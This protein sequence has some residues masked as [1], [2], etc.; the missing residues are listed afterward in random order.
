M[1]WIQIAS[2]RPLHGR[3]RKVVQ[4]SLGTKSLKEAQELRW[5]WVNAYARAWEKAQA[6]PNMTREEI[7][8]EALAEHKRQEKLEGRS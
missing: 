7:E 2:P 6:D 4:K 3:V 1:F 5:A 8:E